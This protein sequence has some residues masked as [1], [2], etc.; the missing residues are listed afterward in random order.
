MLNKKSFLSYFPSFLAEKLFYRGLLKSILQIIQLSTNG[1]GDS[2]I[3]FRNMSER[4][5]NVFLFCVRE[6]MINQG[7][8]LLSMKGVIF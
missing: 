2:F 5:K 1:S 8:N 3:S 7:M 4:K 6:C